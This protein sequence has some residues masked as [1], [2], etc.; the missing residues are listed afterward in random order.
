LNI[1]GE[2]KSDVR[3]AEEYMKLIASGEPL[4]ACYKSQDFVNF[5][6]RVKLLFAMNGQLTSSDTS[7]G[8]TRRL[9]IVD[10]PVSFVDFPDPSNPYER[11][12]DVDIAEKLNAEL[13]SGGIFNWVYAGYKLLGTVNYFT[14]T[15]DQ[16]ELLNEFKRASNPVLRFYEEEILTD[17][18]ESIDNTTLYGK[19]KQW[20]CDSGEAAVSS[21]SFHREFKSVSKS[22]YTAYRTSKERGY[23]KK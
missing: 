6:S 5:I 11:L 13:H 9:V 19:Y 2:I 10:F 21:I 22:E 18:P 16:E 8:L 7:D 20:C 14:E 12:K 1:A 3:D 4:S 23:R 15:N 17:L